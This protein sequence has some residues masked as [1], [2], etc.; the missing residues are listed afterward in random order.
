LLINHW[1]DEI[2]FRVGAGDPRA[3]C[4]GPSGCNE[5]SDASK[6]SSAI[7]AVVTDDPSEV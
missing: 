2:H 1:E 4:D 6:L 5:A 7:D 3:V